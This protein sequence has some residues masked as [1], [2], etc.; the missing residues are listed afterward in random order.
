MSTDYTLAWVGIFPPN[1]QHVLERVSHKIG[2]NHL[3]AR[4][5]AGV[6]LEVCHCHSL[7]SLKDCR[8]S[9]DIHRHLQAQSSPVCPHSWIGQVTQHDS[10]TCLCQKHVPQV[11]DLPEVHQCK[12]TRTHSCP[13]DTMANACTCMASDVSPT[14]HTYCAK[15]H[16]HKPWEVQS[17][18][19]AAERF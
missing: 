10:L 14:S 12:I 2:N 16:Q 11:Q 4:E 18:F 17:K 7:H 5:V 9:A 6:G 13:N 15:F 1:T 19:A 8:R 3:L